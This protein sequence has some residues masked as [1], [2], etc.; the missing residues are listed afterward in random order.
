[1]RLKFPRDSI[2]LLIPSRLILRHSES[3]AFARLLPPYLS[4][5]E[6]LVSL[7]VELVP[8]IVLSRTI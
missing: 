4:P 2:T 3:L 5:S 8:S 1:M 7:F 6:A